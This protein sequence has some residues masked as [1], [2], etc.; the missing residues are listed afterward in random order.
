M[1]GVV[2]LD[3][4]LEGLSCGV[5]QILDRSIFFALEFFDQFQDDIFHHLFAQVADHAPF[6]LSDNAAN[7]GQIRLEVATGKLFTIAKVPRGPGFTLFDPIKNALGLRAITRS[8]PQNKSI[9]ASN[10]SAGVPNLGIELFDV[11]SEPSIELRIFRVPQRNLEIVAFFG[12]ISRH[13]P[14]PHQADPLPA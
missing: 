10:I 2:F 13:R 11:L 1:I 4:V 8:T 6:D 5:A 3:L 7:I 12:K 9:V 14:H